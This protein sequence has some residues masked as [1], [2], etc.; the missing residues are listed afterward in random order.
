MRLGLLAVWVSAILAMV[1]VY[2]MF[3]F[4]TPFIGTVDNYAWQYM[5][6]LNASSVWKDL[7]I[8]TQGT[9]SMAWSVIM[10]VLFISLIL[11]VVVNSARREPQEE[12]YEE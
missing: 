2:V 7:Y 5:N 6:V 11:W 1:G 9:L 4:L 3:S 12:Y 8:S 10:I